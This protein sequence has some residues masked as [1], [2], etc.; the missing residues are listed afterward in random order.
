MNLSSGILAKTKPW[1]CPPLRNVPILGDQ[2]TSTAFLEREWETMWSKVWLL[3]GRSSEMPNPGDYQMEE[4][5]H[6]SF[7]MTRQIDGSIRAFYNVCQ[8]RGSRLVFQTEGFADPITCPYHGWKWAFDGSLTYV[9]DPE[10]FSE[11]NPCDDLNLVEVKC[12]VFAG[13]VWVNMDSNSVALSE[14]LGPVWDEFEAYES[15]NWI[16]GLSSTVDVPCNWKIPQDNSCES[17]HLPS[18]HP[19]GLRWIEHDYKYCHFDWCSEGHNRMAIPM[20]TPSRSL[21]GSDLRIDEQ[22]TAILEPWGLDVHAFKG[23]EFETREAVQKAK[24]KQGLE[25]G[26][27][28]KNLYDDQLTDAYHYNIFPNVTISF[29]AAEYIGLQ[30]MRPH[31]RDPQRHFYDNF[32]YLAPGTA[33][34]ESITKTEERRFFK[35]GEE[36]MNRQIAD[37][38]LGICSGQQLGLASRGYKGVRISGQESRV[39]RF[40]DVLDDYLEGIRP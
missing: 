21:E 38:D 31:P 6:E 30:R 39:Q 22:L 18:V 13:F 3:M 28:F 4:I 7:L 25:K 23:K 40:H 11:G 10:D 9:Q 32:M 33:Q 29:A 26:Y 36:L 15:Q 20:A 8:H 24:R 14:Y 2:Y 1:D 35:Y 16:R 5:G 34:K 12:E 17:Y 27:Q 37:Q 19:Q